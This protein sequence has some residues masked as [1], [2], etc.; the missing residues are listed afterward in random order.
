MS[1]FQLPLKGEMIGDVEYK[2]YTRYDI[3]ME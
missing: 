1:N 3:E 2:D